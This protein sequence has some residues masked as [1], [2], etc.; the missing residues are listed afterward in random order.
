MAELKD[1]LSIPRLS[2]VFGTSS[3]AILSSL[4]ACM[5]PF[6][7]DWAPHY[8]LYLVVNLEFWRGAH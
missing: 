4:K 2:D 7:S 1:F 8:V 3:N 5:V 6:D